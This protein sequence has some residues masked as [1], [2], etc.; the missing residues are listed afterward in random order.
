MRPLILLRDAGLC[1]VC[2]AAGILTPG[3]NT[4]DHIIN[5][6]AGGTDDPSNLRTICKPCHQAKTQTEANAGRVASGMSTTSAA[7]L[8]RVG[9]LLL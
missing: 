2:K 1:Q 4:V 7:P 5:K 3:C 6:A 8:V 9:W